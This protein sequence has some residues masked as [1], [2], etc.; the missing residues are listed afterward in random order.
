MSKKV[1]P[2]VKAE[3]WCAG[4]AVLAQTVPDWIHDDAFAVKSKVIYVILDKLAIEESF[5]RPNVAPNPDAPVRSAALG[6]PASKQP[7]PPRVKASALPF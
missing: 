1:V 6:L 3:R 7:F 4:V 5:D 2:P